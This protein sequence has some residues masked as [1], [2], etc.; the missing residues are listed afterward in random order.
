MK[1]G[2][3]VITAV[4]SDIHLQFAWDVCDRRT[5]R[6]GGDFR[7]GYFRRGVTPGHPPLVVFDGFLPGMLPTYVA[8]RLFPSSRPRH[9]FT[10]KRPCD[11]REYLR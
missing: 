4:R 10:A 2:S 1:K 3:A 6:V 8:T 5:C 9:P 7:D 11:D